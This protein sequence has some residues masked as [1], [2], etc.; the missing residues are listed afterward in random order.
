MNLDVGDS[1]LN[2][3]LA[4]PAI[5]RMFSPLPHVQKHSRAKSA[6]WSW[7]ANLA[8]FLVLRESVGS[9][10]PFRSFWK[11]FSLCP[12]MFQGALISTVS[13]Y[14]C[15]VAQNSGLP[16]TSAL[17]FLYRWRRVAECLRLLGTDLCGS[18]FHCLSVEESGFAITFTLS[19]DTKPL[20]L[21]VIDRFRKELFDSSHCAQ[22]SQK[23][24]KTTYNWNDCNSNLSESHR[25]EREPSEKTHGNLIYGRA[26]E[27]SQCY[28]V[29]RL[30]ER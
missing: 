27:I 18:G 21:L 3:L 8:F 7:G 11:R 28:S 22:Q 13:A 15:A 24:K 14:T 9:S 20:Y 12:W 17:F 25:G 23:D 26:P 29:N 4:L 5:R 10:F 1:E 2:T 30:A 6:G 16:W 19:N